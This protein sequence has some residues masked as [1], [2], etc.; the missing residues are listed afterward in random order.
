[1]AAGEVKRIGALNDESIWLGAPLKATGL[2]G[3]AIVVQTYTSAVTYT[4]QDRDLL[5]YIAQH[6][7]AA[8]ERVRAL[9]QIRQQT[10]E[11][12]TVNSVVQALAAQLD[13][14]PL[15]ELVGDRMRETFD[16]DIVYVAVVD[17]RRR[18]IEFPYYFEAG[19]NPPPMASL[20]LGEGLT[21]RIIET[22]QPALLNNAAQMAS[23]TGQA[24]VG[25]PVRSYLGVPIVLRDR[26]IGA[27]SVQSIEREGRFDSAD[28]QL[29]TTL[30]ANVG[31]AIHNAWLYREAGRRADE[32][33][34]LAEL[35]REA[36]ATTNLDRLLARI[37]ERAR[38]LLES[39]T[40]AV[41]LT[42]PGGDM[43]RAS[44][45]V[46]DDA[47]AIASD[48]IRLGEGIIGDLA[49]RGA[50]EL[51]NDTAADPRAIPIPGTA[52]P[53]EGERL[54]TAPLLVR[55]EVIGMMAVWRHA[56]STRLSDQDLSFLT[57][58]SQQA[59][60]AIDNARLLK[61]AQEARELAEQ[62]NTAKSSFLAAMSHEI[63]T[64]MNAIIGMSGLL[65][66]TQLTS[67]Q[68]DYASVVASSAESLLGVINDI[69][70]FSK[71]EAGRIEL[72][73]APFRLRDAV[74]GVIDTIGPLADG[75]R[76]DLVYDLDDGVPD[77]VVGDVTRLRQ[78]LINLLNNAI[79]FTESGE[80]SLMVR[81]RQ[82]GDARAE[83]EFEVRD[84]G[85]G[86]P[87]EKIESL[88]ESFS[89]ADAS[90]SRRY[91]GTGLGLAISRRLAEL[92]DGTI[93]AES[94]GVPGRGSRVVSTI[95]L[96][97]GEAVQPAAPE[98]QGLVGRRLL[99]VDD[100]D[101]NRKLVSRHASAWGM[102]VVD[103]SSGANALSIVEDGGRFDVI[104]VGL[105]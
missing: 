35:G 21:G 69:L 72:E 80:V 60:A 20:P 26:A 52:P 79:K 43:L 66:D 105:M 90:T 70:D 13:F 40:C 12:E 11:L 101:T 73:D 67:E 6:I 25:T 33:A 5:A 53:E 94:E 8:L 24:M 61:A 68:R 55:D 31:V 38:D 97:V 95:Q 3:G 22:M 4:E 15:L 82:S 30:A 9:E 2:T 44:V 62:A 1:M 98:L 89:Q 47:E 45:V 100:N 37:A 10:I 16:A 36:L 81:A 56:G 42:E 17:E 71:I 65:L 34:A 102:D 28:V 27:I 85:I 29:L 104:M 57:G 78:I 23:E 91:G 51:V 93:V 41:F 58:L 99:V 50:A 39:A 92:M 48:A 63:R 83:L 14:D 54:M 86:I 49:A 46:G 7:G 32:M 87:P 18:R 88:F 74:E 19:D 59:A 84:T 103:A 77:T 76:L 75:K 96:Q 64:P